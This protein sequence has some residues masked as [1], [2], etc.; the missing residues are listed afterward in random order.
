ME[1]ANSLVRGRHVEETLIGTSE[2]LGHGASP[3]RATSGA[4]LRDA[5]R[6]ET[7]S[8]QTGNRIGLADACEEKRDIRAHTGASIIELSR[9]MH[10]RAC[11]RR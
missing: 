6:P 5:R 10:A 7:A 4:D 2:Q 1:D 9:V 3:G 8:L 11:V